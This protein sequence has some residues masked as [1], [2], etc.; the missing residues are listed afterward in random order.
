ME[1]YTEYSKGWRST[2]R[3]RICHNKGLDRA[4]EYSVGVTSLDCH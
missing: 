4:T 3:I 2:S 1:Y